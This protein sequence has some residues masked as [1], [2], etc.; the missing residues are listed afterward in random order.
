[1]PKLGTFCCNNPADLLK[2]E[3]VTDYAAIVCVYAMKG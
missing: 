2:V 1:M 3:A